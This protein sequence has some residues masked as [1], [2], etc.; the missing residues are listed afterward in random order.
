MCQAL[1][2]QHHVQNCIT[3][4]LASKYRDNHE[5]IQVQNHPDKSNQSDH[6]RADKASRKKV[7]VD[8]LHTSRADRELVC[9][10][11]E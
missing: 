1:T 2:G 3:P 11:V 5:L 8:H 6:L 10:S 4:P 9:G 7:G